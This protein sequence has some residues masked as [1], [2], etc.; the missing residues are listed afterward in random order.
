MFFEIK[1]K[2]VFKTKTTYYLRKYYF[3][4]IKLNEIPDSKS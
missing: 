2:F 3:V 1:P 4:K